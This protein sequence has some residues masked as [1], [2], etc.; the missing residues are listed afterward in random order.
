[1][2]EYDHII[3]HCFIKFKYIITFETLYFSPN[4]S[5]NS[6]AISMIVFTKLISLISLLLSNFFLFVKISVCS[7]SFI[8]IPLINSSFV[9]YVRPNWNNCL[10]KNGSD[11]SDNDEIDNNLI[12]SSLGSIMLILLL[13]I[14]LYFVTTIYY[15]YTY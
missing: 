10:P 1:M 12:I 3:T 9:L 11:M 8:I 14:L 2:K 13:F 7:R 4:V 6:L 5:V 15:F